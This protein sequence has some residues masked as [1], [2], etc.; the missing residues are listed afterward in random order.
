MRLRLRTGLAALAGIILATTVGAALADAK[1][2]VRTSM[3]VPPFRKTRDAGTGRPTQGYTGQSYTFS[4][5]PAAGENVAEYQYTVV[6]KDETHPA[7]ANGSRPAD[8]LYRQAERTTDSTFTY[9]FYLEGTYGIFAYRFDAEGNEV[10]KNYSGV[11][12]PFIYHEIIISEGTG[13]N[14]LTA[15]VAE[16]AATCETWAGARGGTDYA[17][18]LAIN[19][20]LC[21]NVTY[22]YSYQYYSPEAALLN[23]S[24]VCNG[25]SRA[26]KLIAD[27][28]GLSCKRVSGKVPPY[29][30][31]S[32]H[33][34]NAVQMDQEWYYVDSTWN[35]D[36]M[37]PDHRYFGMNQTIMDYDH[38]IT[39][40][41]DGA[42]T[43]DEL[44]NSYYIQSGTW[45][46]LA[47]DVLPEMEAA[48]NGRQHLFDAVSM[49]NKAYNEFGAYRGAAQRFANGHVIV[50][51]FNH[52][53]WT[54][55][56]TGET[57]S[58]D[59]FTY[60]ATTN[61]FSGMFTADG[62]LTLPSGL[63]AIGEQAFAGTDA[64]Y[65]IVPSDC[66]RIDAEAFSG[67]KMWEISIPGTVTEIDERAFDGT[68]GLVIRTPAGSKAATMFSGDDRFTVIEQEVETR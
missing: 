60:D 5:A 54:C 62:T 53:D 2:G 49:G 9:P 58:S 31:N 30:E 51:A 29:D 66:E 36:D 34:W 35:D 8:A 4:F 32:G 19:E 23:G 6:I 47:T 68:M 16:V 55:E 65:V 56:A 44:E 46:T 17:K 64:Y 48:V 45:E 10:Y 14:A 43:C 24:C 28:M 13:E 39:N 67:S 38:L 7:G 12:Y 27:Q 57:F 37:L 52:R 18:A 21:D 22:D 1:P 26:Y 63:K 20:W 40:V 59:S 33:A 11:L 41:V 50:Y 15:K 25:Y 61:S 3:E 42:V